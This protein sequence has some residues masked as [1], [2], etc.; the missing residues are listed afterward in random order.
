MDHSRCLRRDGGRKWGCIEGRDRHRGPGPPSSLLGPYPLRPVVFW[1][2]S[3]LSPKGPEDRSGGSGVSSFLL[4]KEEGRGRPEVGDGTATCWE[5]ESNL[6]LFRKED[7]LSREPT[8]AVGG[9]R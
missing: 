4:L 3:D 9:R 7:R 5:P 1:G 6:F 8:S 2:L